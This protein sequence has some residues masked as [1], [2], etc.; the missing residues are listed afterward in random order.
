MWRRCW[1]RQLAAAADDSDPP[2]VENYLLAEIASLRRSPHIEPLRPS[3]MST[4]VLLWQMQASEC[5][6][7]EG[8]GTL[9]NARA[10]S[11][12]FV[13][14][15]ACGSGDRDEDMVNGAVEWIMGGGIVFV[16]ILVILVL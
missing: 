16:W 4:R 15:V 8:T 7:T 11:R 13:V 1:P 14:E 10:L 9:R 5:P 12:P 6:K 3:R 2:A